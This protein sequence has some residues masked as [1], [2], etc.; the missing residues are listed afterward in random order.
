MSNLNGILIGLMT[1]QS[2]ILH[3]AVRG[4]NTPD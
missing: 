4:N 3:S 2:V 1:D